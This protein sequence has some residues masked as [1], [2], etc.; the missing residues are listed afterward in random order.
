MLGKNLENDSLKS[1]FLFCNRKQALT[2]HVNWS[3]KFKKKKIRE[4]NQ[5][6]PQSQRLFSGENIIDVVCWIIP[7]SG[8]G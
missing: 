7:E 4:D 5:E 6:M 1:Y 3:F 2:V 8:K